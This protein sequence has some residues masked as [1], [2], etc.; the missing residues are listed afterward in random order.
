VTLTVQGLSEEIRKPQGE[1]SS[2]LQAVSRCHSSTSKQI[3][4]KFS[5]EMYSWLYSSFL[6]NHLFDYF[7]ISDQ[8]PL[9]ITSGFKMKII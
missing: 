1:I 8:V 5:Y 7:Y 6:Q 2:L 4:G 9:A 3:M